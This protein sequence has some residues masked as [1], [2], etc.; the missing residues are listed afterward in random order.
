[1]N[2]LSLSRGEA[3]RVRILEVARTILSAEGLERFVL[4]E[5]AKRAGMQLGNLQYYFATRDDLLEAVIRDE[6]DHNLAAIRGLDASDLAAYLGQFTDLMIRE[7]TGIGGTIWPVLTVL[8]LHH[9]R[10]RELSE[11]IY[12]EQFDILTDVM[13]RFGV[14]GTTAVLREKARM[15]TAVVDG[16]ALQAHTG[17]HSRRSREWR[18]VCRRTAEIV[19]V[20]ATA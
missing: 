14:T 16:A 20:I 7:Y 8:H 1:M 2:D 13:T 11:E 17:P 6:F 15:I 5:I 19:V 3:S 10:F 18:A 9:R 12:R 4:R